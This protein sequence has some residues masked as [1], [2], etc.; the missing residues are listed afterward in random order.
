MIVTLLTD[1]GFEDEYVGVL[2]GVIHGINPSS[3]LIDISH[4]VIPGD[5][6][7]A[8]WMLSWSWSY[9]PEG[10]IHIAVVDPGVGSSRKILCCVHKK[11]FFLAPD[12]GLLSPLLD[13]VK[14]PVVYSITNRNYM[15]KSISRT[16]HGRDIFAPIAGHLSKGVSISRLGA[17]LR[18]GIKRLKLTQPRV[19]KGSF[20]GRII[21][22]DRFGN[23]VTNL[24]ENLLEKLKS[25]RSLKVLVKR[26]PLFPIVQAYEEVI[27]GSPLAVIG[28]RGLLEIS[29]NG[30]SAERRLH[31]K[32]G[33]EISIRG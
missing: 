7:K 33:D 18:T 12:N 14:Q 28:S 26:H 29:V 17:R 30:G 16:F 20:S 1:F 27:P 19:G 8:G 23:A 25:R 6:L 13:G 22:F 32:V 11:H 15:L 10:S 4:Q 31:L 2:K 3:T 5:V 24:P 9:F 21:G